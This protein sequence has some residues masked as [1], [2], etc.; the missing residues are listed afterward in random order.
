M[1]ARISP[2]PRPMA[3]PVSSDIKTSLL[4]WG[5]FMVLLSC[6]CAL[7]QIVVERTPADLGG[8]FSH[9]FK[10]WGVW[11]LT[12]P[13]LFAALRKYS[14]KWH[15]RAVEFVAFVAIVVFL[16]TA[17]PVA[18]D[19]LTNARDAASSLMI[20]LPR[21]V[22]A[23]GIVYLVWHAF[24]RDRRSSIETVETPPP[25]MIEATPDEPVVHEA[26]APEP[27]ATLLV[28]KGAHQC[29]IQISR[30]ECVSAA[31][32]YVEIIERGQRYLMRATLKQL[33]DELPAGEF[34][35]IHRSHLVR[36]DEIDLIKSQPSGNG[37]VQLRGGHVLPM[38]KKHKQALQRFRHAD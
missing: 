36:R 22:A 33:E 23:V 29:L 21:Y 2:L 18:V 31:G 34:I 1:S 37:T 28:S 10:N 11:L 5:G 12:T 3:W 38:S 9:V 35:R 20:F 30:I 17:V 16:S 19:L 15:D 4:C 14:T 25:P 27:P 8:S 13:V 32:N 24:L 7:F 6:Y 26:V